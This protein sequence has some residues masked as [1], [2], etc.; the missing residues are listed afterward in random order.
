MFF[1]R[2][3][4]S[5]LEDF[6]EPSRGTYLERNVS[7]PTL[8]GMS[9]RPADTSSII[10][11]DKEAS[12]YTPQAV[13]VAESEE[14]PRDVSLK[15]DRP[16]PTWSPSPEPRK[17][18]RSARS[19]SPT[20]PLRDLAPRPFG[21][22]PTRTGH[23]DLA[24]NGLLPGTPSQ[25]RALP[26]SH[27]TPTDRKVLEY[28][29]EDDELMD[30]GNEAGSVAGPD[31]GPHRTVSVL[32][33]DNDE[34]P[35]RGPSKLVQPTLIGLGAGWKLTRQQDDGNL[36][37]RAPATKPTRRDTKLSFR[38]R[39]A[40]FASQTAKVDTTMA[41]SDS[42]DEDDDQ[43]EASRVT[44]TVE[45]IQPDV[46][47]R[48]EPNSEGIDLDLVTMLEEEDETPRDNLISTIDLPGIGR[49]SR[50]SE[51]EQQ[52][53]T[54]D[55]I[56]YIAETSATRG[57]S[58]KRRE[59]RDEIATRASKREVVISCDLD[60]IRESFQKARRRG[61]AGRQRDPAPNKN[62]TSEILPA[63]GVSNQDSTEVDR[64][65]SRVIKKQDFAGMRIIGQYNKAFIIAR[66]RV[67]AGEGEGSSDDLFII[68]EPVQV[69]ELD[70][71]YE[72]L[73]FPDQHAADE[74]Y[75]FET[76]QAI[77]KIQSQRLIQ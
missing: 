45:V 22:T 31:T 53:E 39:L 77:T 19:P 68:G 6:Y 36:S 9:S 34:A 3:S 72:T 23:G 71:A 76:L 40:G 21:G 61:L 49:P 55:P 52:G 18:T 75:N 65:L 41:D 56:Q 8:R 42:D 12:P 47:E 66:R 59:F 13:Q 73:T 50:A 44:R 38:D 35:R 11:A 37:D 14:S 67:E 62:R 64:T 2:R 74:K 7:A 58:S 28:E 20:S 4:Q 30:S 32:D 5:A 24:A 15:R 43:E 33:S 26:A 70:L 17:R 16:I 57:E 46:A 51:V 63:A 69:I 1:E 54:Q 10:H 29:E 27:F 60:R 25:V 48:N